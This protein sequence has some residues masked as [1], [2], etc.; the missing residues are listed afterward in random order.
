MATHRVFYS[1]HYDADFWRVQMIR[2]IGVIEGNKP[3]EPNQWE[4]IKKSGDAAIKLWI[5]QNM[6]YRSCVIV[7][8]GE[9]TSER[10]YVK[11]EIEKAWNDER[12]L[13]GIYIH[14][15][16]D[17]NSRTSKKG[18]NPFDSFV[19]PGTDGKRMSEF[20]RC[21]NPTG[22]S[23]EVYNTIADN[24]AAW[25]EQAISDIKNRPR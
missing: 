3:A 2:N 25:I 8:I 12:A 1:F 20:V 10:K 7:L 13:L 22:D 17:S 5:N 16:K 23:K 15:L 21:Y 19:I 24:I 4:E 18:R 11:Y 6:M 14:N 9:F